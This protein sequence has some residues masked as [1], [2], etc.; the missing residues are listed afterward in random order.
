MDW[1]TNNVWAI[2]LCAALI[3]GSAELL[4]GDMTL[5]MLA[6]AALAGAVTAGVLPGLVAAQIAVA[7]VV[8]LASLA[9]VR[10]ALRRQL[11]TA[12]GY[13]N[14]IETLVG[15]TAVVSAPIGPDST[16]AVKVNG[17]TWTARAWEPTLSLA[18]SDQVEVVEIDGATLVVRPLP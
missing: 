10:P 15:S 18:T 2:W 6:L 1:F 11:E 4:T 16:G 5:L 14:S 13:R 8:A 12:R 17:D 9:L 3:L 7:A